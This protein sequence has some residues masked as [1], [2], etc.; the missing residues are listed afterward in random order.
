MRVS[1]SSFGGLVAALAIGLG[2]TLT[3]QQIVIPNGFAATEGSSSTSYPWNRTNSA[4]RVQYCYD[5]SMF[6]LQ[7]VNTPV[8]L[9]RCK[10]RVN[11]GATS[12][13]GT[14]NNVTI[15]LSTSPL[16]YS[17]ITGTF[18]SNHGANITRVYS[19]SVTVAPAAGTTPNNYYVDVTFQTPFPYDPSQGDL[20]FDIAIPGASW[21][22]GTAGA[23]DVEFTANAF[24]NRVYNLTSATATTG[25]TQANVGPVIQLDFVP[26]GGTFANAAPYGSGCYDRHAS[27]YEL[28]LANGF[29]LSNSSILLQP[30]GGGGY[31]VL[32]GSNQW[33]TPVSANLGLVDDSVSAA[34]TMPFAFPFPDAMGATISSTDLFISSNGFV[35][36]ATSTNNGCCNGDP[37]LLL[38]QGNRFAPIWQDLNP[39]AGGTVHFDIDPSNTVAYVTWLGVPEFGQ[40]NTNTCQAAFYSDGRVEY[41]YQGCVNAAHN[42]LVGWSH[43]VA[44]RSPGNRDLSAAIPFATSTDQ[45]PLALAAGSRPVIG[46]TVA[47]NTSSIPVGTFVGATILGFAQMVPP[48]DLTPLGMPGCLQH[49]SADVTQLFFPTGSTGS[50]NLALPNNPSIVGASIYGQSATFS[51]GFNPLGVITSNGLA[52][53]LGN[54]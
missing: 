54:V 5:S 24:C 7:S 45:A 23:L 32:P 22:G 15:D 2:A 30:T 44:A 14:Y 10:W 11:G 51:A 42:L 53:L 6:T 8:I 49:I 26:V 39:G 48:I 37:A 31:A 33:F 1:P 18:A 19:G 34:Q 27:F 43:G 12:T 40:T 28:F 35:W 36:T 47:L 41:R 52:L 25:T 20:L 9:Q 16:N 4:I 13:G 29:D 3:A 46:T 38:S 50:T 17:A 21:T